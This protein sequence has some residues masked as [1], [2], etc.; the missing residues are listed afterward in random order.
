MFLCEHLEV[1]LELCVLGLDIACDLKGAVE[2]LL[3]PVRVLCKDLDH[4]IGAFGTHS[5]LAIVLNVISRPHAPMFVE[6]S[7]EAEESFDGC[8]ASL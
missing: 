3:H 5:D 4:L 1:L 6:Y 2:A 8:F 7:H